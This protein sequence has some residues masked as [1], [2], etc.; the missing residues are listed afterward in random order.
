MEASRERLPLLL[1]AEPQSY[2]FY[3]GNGFEETTHA[4]FDLSQWAPAYSGFGI[5]RLAGMRWLPSR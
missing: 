4:D 5:F 2:G 1:C 3:A